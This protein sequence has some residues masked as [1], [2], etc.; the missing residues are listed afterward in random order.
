MTNTTEQVITMP[1]AFFTNLLD[2]VRSNAKSS[3]IPRQM[4]GNIQGIMEFEALVCYHAKDLCSDYDGGMWD[5]ATTKNGKSFIMY[6]AHEKSFSI[7][8][9]NTYTTVLV[10]SRIFGFLT[11][12]TTFSHGSFRYETKNPNLSQTLAEH[13]HELKNVFDE[14]ITSMLD[15]TTSTATDE[16]K[17]QIREMSRAVWSILD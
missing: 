7:D 2:R 4:K 3:V 9:H 16:E 6:P 17:E 11:T 15:N 8:N 12:L 5:F 1:K 14:T 10:D 13:Y